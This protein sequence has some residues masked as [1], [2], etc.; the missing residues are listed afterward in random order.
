M[1]D[2]FTIAVQRK[3]REDMDAYANKI[4]SGSCKTFE[5]YKFACGVIQGL[6]FAKGHLLDLAKLVEEDADE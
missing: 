2:R 5:E 4:A 6:T 3:L 1:I